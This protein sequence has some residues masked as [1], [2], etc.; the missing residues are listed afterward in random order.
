MCG[1]LFRQLVRSYPVYSLACNVH[2][3]LSIPAAP[4]RCTC[5]QVSL[6]K[7]FTSMLVS[8]SW[9]SQVNWTSNCSMRLFH[10]KRIHWLGNI[11]QLKA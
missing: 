10:T 1:G 5:Q 4:N 8:E 7:S 9:C 3:R 2:T 11:D 6:L